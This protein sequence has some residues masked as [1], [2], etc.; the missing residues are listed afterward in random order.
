MKA[1]AKT[2]IKHNGSY[3]KQGDTLPQM[4]EAELS[5]LVAVDAIAI[6]GGIVKPEPPVN[7]QAAKADKTQE[8]EENAKVANLPIAITLKKPV[9]IGIARAN[10]L[11]VEKTATPA[12]VYRMIKSYR[13]SKGIVIE[14]PKADK[15]LVKADDKKSTKEVEKETAEAKVKEEIELAEKEASKVEESKEK[16]ENKVTDEEVVESKDTK[17]DSKPEAGEEAKK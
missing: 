6:E 8:T 5:K 4:T 11:T 15:K 1:I 10:G 12:E 2:T 7:A 16:A 9:L 14:E 17:K 3:F 13:D